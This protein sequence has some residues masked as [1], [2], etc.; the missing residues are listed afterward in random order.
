LWMSHCQVFQVLKLH[1][2][3]EINIINFS[4]FRKGTY[5]IYKI[6]G[7]LNAYQL[8]LKRSAET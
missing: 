3:P 6:Y 8:L 4:F 7:T 1:Y 5:E 2:A